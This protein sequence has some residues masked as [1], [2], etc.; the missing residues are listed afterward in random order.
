MYAFHDSDGDGLGD[1]KGIAEK[2][3]Y[4]TYLGID[5]IWL[6][7]IHPSPSYHHY[8]VT[9]YFAVD[10]AYE[11]DGFTFDDFELVNYQAHPHIKAPVAI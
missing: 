7:P 10:P 8:D 5:A 1:F 11:V 9:D 4:L 3:D 2:V 6:S